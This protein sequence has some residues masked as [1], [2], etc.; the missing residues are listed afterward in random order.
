MR[1]FLFADVGGANLQ[2]ML[3]LTS[4]GVHFGERTLF[5]GVDLPLVSKTASDWWAEMAQASRHC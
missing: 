3:H 1:P 2:A 5:E 4:L